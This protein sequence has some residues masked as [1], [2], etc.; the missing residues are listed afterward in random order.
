MRVIREILRI[1]FEFGSSHREIGRAVNKSPSTVGL[2]LSKFETA[3]LSWPLPDD[4]SDEELERRL[5]PAPPVVEDDEVRPEPDWE[6]VATELAKKHVTLNLLWK[7]YQKAHADKSPYQYTWFCNQFRE[8]ESR[9]SVTMRLSHK[10][11]EKMFVDWAGT[12]VPIVNAKTGEVT[13]AS[14]FVATLGLSSYTYVEAFENEKTPAWIAGHTNACQYFEGVSEITVPDNPKTG[15]TKA[16]FCE[17]DINPVYYAWS[18]HN[19]TAII[20]ARRRK[21]KDKA[22]VECGVKV[23]GMW[24]LARLR[25]MTFYSVGELNAAIWELL[26]ELNEE[27]FQKRPGSRRS[28]FEEQEKAALKPLP[29]EPF[30]IF[31]FK[32]ARV[33]PDY[34]VQVEGHFYSV[35]FTLI[36]EV[37]EVCIRPRI[38]QVFHRSRMVATHRRSTAVGAHT[39]LPEHMP[40][41]H[42]H[43]V[44]WTPERFESWALRHGTSVRDF[45]A[46]LMNR[47][48]HVQQAFR[49]C[50][51]LMRLSKQF[52]SQRL[53]AACLRALTLGAFRYK[54]VKSIL[55]KGLDSSPLPSDISPPS[56]SAGHHENVRGSAYYSQLDLFSDN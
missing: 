47:K 49:S 4:L 8:W 24:I 55:E 37:L 18:E 14:I 33:A 29:A 43:Q 41:H 21:P 56:R 32:K 35:P 52:G 27:P 39:T 12:K 48:K 23:S 10:A 34:H 46:E 20:P 17:P 42:R 16:D 54:S 44:E 40:A 9:K 50:F 51:G 45:V 1:R 36:K 30:E 25:N 7:E 2:C 19:D 38:V 15:V 53:N 22:K 26:E 31:D 11:G 5:Y 6:Y 3:G 13:E 28:W